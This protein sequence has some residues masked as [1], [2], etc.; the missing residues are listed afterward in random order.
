MKALLKYADNRDPDSL[1]NVL[2][3]RRFR[4]FESLCAAAPR[5]LRILDVGGVEHF[6]RFMGYADRADVEIVLLNVK[7]LQPRAA[8][9]SAVVG[10]AREMAGLADREFPIAFSNSV[11]EHVGGL[12]QQA[13]MAS[14]IRR[15]AS[16]YFVQTPNRFFPLETHFLVPGFQFLPLAVR[17]ALVQRFALGYHEALP[18]REEA[19]R[20][21]T[22]I[23]LLTRAELSTLFPGAEI[24]HER[25]AGLTKSFLAVGGWS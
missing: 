24:R 5:P 25:V 4:L 13:R 7:P 19:I 16:R 18:D 6:W 8:N 14:E 1:A 10:D 21:V 20:A 12:E 17:V 2:R 3:R 11:I 22:E 9:I 15:V 23:R